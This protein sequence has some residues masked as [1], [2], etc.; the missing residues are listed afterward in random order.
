MRQGLLDSPS[1]PRRL[2]RGHAVKGVS[3]S[4][5]TFNYNE[6][7]FTGV[8]GNPTDAASVAELAID[9]D[10]IIIAVG[11]RTATVPEET[12]MNQTAIV[13]TEVLAGQ[14][15]AG[16]QVIVIGGGMTMRGSRES[17]IDNMPPNAKEGSAMYA[18][19]LGHWEAYQTYLK[20]EINWTFVAPPMGILGF[21]EGPDIRT[22]TYRAST[23]EYVVTADGKN[24]IS[25]SD[26]AVAAVDFAEEA[27]FNRV[28]VAVGY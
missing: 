6:D 22:G 15:S 5:E 24:E 9:V 3:R 1:S 27:D 2:S 7:N 21:R 8:Q 19:F 12:A 4:P 25:M 11:G 10:A 26:L 23:S 20:S 17:M 18:L 16:P 28:K 13:V 14:G